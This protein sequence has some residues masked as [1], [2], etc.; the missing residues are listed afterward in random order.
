MNAFLTVIA[1]LALL[2]AAPLQAREV[3]GVD[4]PEQARVAGVAEPLRLNG[5]G[6]RRKMLFPVYAVGIYLPSPQGDA[7]PVLAMDGPRRVLM[8]ILH[9]EITREQLVAAWNE[10]FTANHSPAELAPLQ[11]RIDRFD[12]AFETLRGGD[13]VLLDYVPGRG[14]RVEINGRVREEIPGADF[15]AGLLRIWL[16]PSPVS[17][18]LKAELLGH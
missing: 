14:T 17:G 1:L 7:E 13:V 16:G 3:G 15:A 6:V 5:A 18:G 11:A 12:A 10:G 4:L 8:R 9:K 2:L